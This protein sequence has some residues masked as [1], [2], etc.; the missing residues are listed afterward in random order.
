MFSFL[1][2]YP[3][4]VPRTSSP[5]HHSMFPQWMFPPWPHAESIPG[6]ARA[7]GISRSKAPTVSATAAAMTADSTCRLSRKRE[8]NQFVRPSSGP[9][10]PGPEPLYHCGL[11]PRS[12][13]SSLAHLHFFS[14]SASHSWPNSH[15]HGPPAPATPQSVA[16][17]PC[18]PRVREGAGPLS[19][20][21][22]QC[23]SQSAGFLRHAVGV[24]RCGPPRRR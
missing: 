15:D 20:S 1:S 13:T 8:L 16:P 9:I 11:I 14:P 2:T 12:S 21:Q 18:P 24:A 19:E 10:A 6:D 23:K 5:P 17:P 7:R 4:C 3:I 22:F